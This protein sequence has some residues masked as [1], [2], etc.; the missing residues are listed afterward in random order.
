[1]RVFTQKLTKITN[2]FMSHYEIV[3]TFELSYFYRGGHKRKKISCY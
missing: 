1:M 3:Y 2:K